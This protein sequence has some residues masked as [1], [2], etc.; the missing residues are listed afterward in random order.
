MERWPVID[1]HFHVGVNGITTFL[2][3]EDLIPWMDKAGTDIQYVCQLNEGFMHKT[4]EWNPYLGNDYIARIQNMFPDRV[5]GLAT[6]NPYQQAPASYLWPSSREGQ[7]F[8]RPV[9]NET[10]EELDRCFLELGLFGLKMHPYEHGYPVNFRPIIWPMMERLTELQRQVGRTLLILIHG[11]GDTPFNSTEAIGDLAAHFPEIL[12]LHSHAGFIW[13]GFN[14][15]D[16][17]AK[18]DNVMLDLTTCPQKGIVMES[19]RRYGARKFCVGTDGPFVGHHV[20]RNIVYDLT[21]DAEERD[22][23]MGGNLAQRLGI[24][25]VT[26]RS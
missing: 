22:L 11:G 26:A 3:E 16:H 7:R 17:S 13:G 20:P 18:Y 4:P 14:L 10:L 2:A 19:Y 15:A 5:R 8:D 12:F 21:E 25:K 1:T 24:S 23:M 6:I 9:R